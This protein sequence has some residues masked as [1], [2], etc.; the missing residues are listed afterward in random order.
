MRLV[1]GRFT[2]SL[3]TLAIAFGGAAAQASANDTSVKTVIKAQDR[4]IK[5]SPQLKRLLNGTVKTSQISE[6]IKLCHAFAR[7]L[8]HAASTVAKTSA[9]TPNGIAGEKNWVTGVRELAHGFSQLATALKDE[10]GG[11]KAA[12]K[13][14]V[15]AAVKTINA[16]DALGLK[17]DHELKLPR[18]A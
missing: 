1:L 13:R 12:A 18:G 6:A 4:A 14:E 9:S 16:G 7:K 17:A 10:Q 11:N 15:R 2:L 3:A 8:D 5:A